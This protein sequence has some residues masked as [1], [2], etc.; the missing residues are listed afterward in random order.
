MS[1]VAFHVHA[2]ETPVSEGTGFDFSPAIISYDDGFQNPI[3]KLNIKNNRLGAGFILAS[4]DNP[5]YKVIGANLVF[6]RVIF[7]NKH[8]DFYFEAGPTYY[9]QN[10]WFSGENAS[11]LYFIKKYNHLHLEMMSGFRY[12]PFRRW[13]FLAFDAGISYNVWEQTKYEDSRMFYPMRFGMGWLFY[14]RKY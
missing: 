9:K 14:K 12:F 11:Y 2:Q 13:F 5:R 7:F 3:L 1:L 10:K 4:P 8:F 6:D